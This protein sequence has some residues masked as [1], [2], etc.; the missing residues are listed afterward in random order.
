MKG[1]PPKSDPQSL[2]IMQNVQLLA[3]GVGLKE[4]LDKKLWV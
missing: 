3:A 2:R 1:I 4:A